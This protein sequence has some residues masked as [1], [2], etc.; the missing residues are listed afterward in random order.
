VRWCKSEM[1]RKAPC[2]Q[3]MRAPQV[4]LRYAN[5]LHVEIQCRCACRVTGLAGSKG[6]DINLLRM[7]APSY[8]RAV[9][10]DV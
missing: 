10:S 1:R 4:Q 6:T 8:Q 9:D 3:Q 2:L 7:L 5:P